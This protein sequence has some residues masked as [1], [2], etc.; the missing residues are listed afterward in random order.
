MATASVALAN[1]SSALGNLAAAATQ[2]QTG[3]QLYSRAGDTVNALKALLAW[4]EVRVQV[5]DS[6]GCLTACGEC[7]AELRK[8]KSDFVMSQQGQGQHRQQMQQQQMQQQ[9]QQQREE[10]EE[11]LPKELWGMLRK[12]C[13]HVQVSIS[14]ISVTA[15][16]D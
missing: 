5:G 4:A 10:E 2:Y 14:A 12:E 1:T 16:S 9:Q 13:V 3:Q 8:R 15:I 11:T 6:M 7:L